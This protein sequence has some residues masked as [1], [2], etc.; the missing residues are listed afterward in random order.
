MI[1][2][3][4]QAQGFADN[5]GVGS[6]LPPPK[7]VAEHHLQVVAGSGIVRI[8]GATQLRVCTEDREVVGRNGLETESLGL[9]T[10]GEVYVCAV[11][12]NCHGLEY[13]GALEVSPLRDGGADVL[14][15]DAGQVVLDAHHLV[16]IWVRQRA[17]QRGVDYAIDRGGGPDAQRHRGNRDE[18]KSR[19]SQKHANRVTQI[20]EQILEKRE[21][22]FGVIAFADCLRRAEFERGM[23]TRFGS[24]HAGADI[25]RGL[26][27]EMFGELFLQAPVR[28][29][30]S[31]EVKKTNQ[32]TPQGFHDRCSTLTS[33]NRAM[34]A[35]VR[36]QSRVSVCNCLRPT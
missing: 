9:C 16:R 7:P 28:A 30:S 26:L 8:E 6:E 10:T 4:V 34:M 29:P 2:V 25:V 12:G 24:G 14:R 22:L 27:S 15:A 5:A 11:A 20:E 21:A 18:R 35:E 33:K 3:V 13:P 32:E 23:A 36:S 31:C 1:I 19:R 17:Q